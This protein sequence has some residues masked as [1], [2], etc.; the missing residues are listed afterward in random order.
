MNYTGDLTVEPDACFKSSQPQPPLP[1]YN[2]DIKGLDKAAL[3]EV[4]WGFAKSYANLPGSP[5]GFAELL[6]KNL[7]ASEVFA[8]GFKYV[9]YFNGRPIKIDFRQDIVDSRKYD[10]DSKRPF[11][12]VVE[13]VRSRN[14]Q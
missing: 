8:G 9:D 13:L 3:L 1:A 12:D 2:V 6:G 5:A 14:K 7:K 11:A 4:A 10:R